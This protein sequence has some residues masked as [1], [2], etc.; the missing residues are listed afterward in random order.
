MMT[1]KPLSAASPQWLAMTRPL[2]LRRTICTAKC[3]RRLQTVP[4]MRL[5]WPLLRLVRLH[6]L[7]V[8]PWIRELKHPASDQQ[9]RHAFDDPESEAAERV[10]GHGCYRKRRPSQKLM[11]NPS[12]NPRQNALDRRDLAALE[13]K[14]LTPLPYTKIRATQRA[15]AAAW[16]VKR[17]SGDRIKIDTRVC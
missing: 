2:I 17:E 3:S 15:V 12:R 14:R 13:K 8:P 10:A 9:E 4:R 1:L 11:S 6:P 7:P 5:R 16:T